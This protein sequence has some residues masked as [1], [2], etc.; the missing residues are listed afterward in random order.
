MS[1]GTWVLLSGV[2]IVALNVC[3][4]DS[5]LALAQ[6]SQ[7]L[8]YSPVTSAVRTE[9]RT[10]TKGIQW[11]SAKP[12]GHG[13]YMERIPSMKMTDV[14]GAT[15][16]SCELYKQAGMLLMITAPNLQQY[17]KQK[18]WNKQ[19]RKAGWPETNAPKCVVVQ[20]MSQQETYRE[21]ALTMITEKAAEDPLLTFVIDNSG[22]LR[23]RFGVQE[24][25]TI[26]LLVDKDG[27]VVHHE[28][29]DVEPDADSARRVLKIVQAMCGMPAK[30]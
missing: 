10:E 20:D 3:A 25:E 4:A 24:N 19:I 18:R 5:S 1:K 30:K 6:A 14:K 12:A 17:E 7:T 13:H 15:H 27:N 16:D 29:D 28:C 22:D 21:K 8:M 23:R 2:S 11:G 26:I 9:A